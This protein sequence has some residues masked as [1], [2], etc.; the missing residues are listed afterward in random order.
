MLL[1]SNKSISF[2]SLNYLINDGS[3]EGYSDKKIVSVVLKAMSTN[4]LLRNVLETMKRLALNTFLRFLQAHFKEGNA[5]DSSIHLAPM[6]EF[7]DG[8]PRSLM[9]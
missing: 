6:A 8:I 2:V 9:T 1:W 3:T 4:F 5:S 7:S